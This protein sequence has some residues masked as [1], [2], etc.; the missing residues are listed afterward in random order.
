ML[1]C[2]DGRCHPLI[3]AFGCQSSADIWK[4]CDRPPADVGPAQCI[5]LH[6]LGP[7]PTLLSGY[8]GCETKRNYVGNKTNLQ[9]PQGTPALT[10]HKQISHSKCTAHT[11]P[12]A[13]GAHAYRDRSS[14][15]MMFMTG[16]WFR[17]AVALEASVSAV[18]TDTAVSW[19]TESM[20]APS[21]TFTPALGFQK[22]VHASNTSLLRF[23]GLCAA[24][25][26]PVGQ[27]TQQRCRPAGGFA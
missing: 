24:T 6:P 20:F 15:S 11:T 16:S 17:S 4:D 19:V 25:V 22:G 2:S 21:S 5:T 27:K 7:T 14:R 1:G 12:W 9:A 23:G 18:N 10:G 26:S 13:L 3:Q 8:T